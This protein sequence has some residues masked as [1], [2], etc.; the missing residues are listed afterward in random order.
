MIA[1]LES[2]CT[3]AGDA[4]GA[5]GA[6]LRTR[7]EGFADYEAGDFLLAGGRMESDGPDQTDPI[8]TSEVRSAFDELPDSRLLNIAATVIAGW[9]PILLKTTGD[10]TDVDVLVDALRDRAAQ[11]AAVELDADEPF[12]SPA[13]LSAHLTHSPRRGE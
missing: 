5:A 10:L 1:A 11:F 7:R 4:L 2:L 8:P 9:K 12:P 13:H 6:A 3:L